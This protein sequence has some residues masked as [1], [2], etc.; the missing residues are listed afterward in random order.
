[1]LRKSVEGN[2]PASTWFDLGLARQDLGDLSGA[3]A[4]YRHALGMKPDFAEAAVNLGVVQQEAG[5][6]DGA[7]ESYGVAY[8]LRPATFGTIAMALTSGPHGRLWLDED[9]LR[10]SLGG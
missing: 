1:L 6:M 5:D 2:A 10:R 7:L 4:A 8:R 3:T 9:S